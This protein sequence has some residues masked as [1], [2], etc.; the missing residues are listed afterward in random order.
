MFPLWADVPPTPRVP[1]TSLDMPEPTQAVVIGLAVSAVVVAV[2]L[3]WARWSR[4]PTWPVLILAVV[5]LALSGLAGVYANWS[6]ESAQKNYRGGERPPRPWISGPGS[7]RSVPTTS[8]D[9]T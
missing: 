9:V 5:L 3:V 2:G 4:R 7:G 6:Y 1:G 8:P